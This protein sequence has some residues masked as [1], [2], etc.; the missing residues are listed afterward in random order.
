MEGKRETLFFRKWEEL[1]EFMRI[2]EVRPYWEVLNRKKTQL[3]L[4]RVVDIVLSLLMIVLLSVPMIVVAVL[5]RVDSPGPVFF[6]Q[7][8]VTSYGKHFM[9]HKFRTMVDN[10]QSLGSTV[11]VKGDSRI[12]RVGQTLRKL[13][14]DEL[15]QLFDVLSGDMSFVGTRPEAVKYV[16]MYRP[17]YLATLL[18]PAGITSAAS[19]R[20]KDE[21]ELL[22]GADDVDSVYI[23]QILPEK[24]KWNLKSIEEFSLIGDLKTMFRTVGAVLSKE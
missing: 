9:I 19:I 1:P 24:M 7:A 3:I 4:K 23:K 15:P 17:E 16:E 8:R 2:P 18:M 20:Y 14:I 22:N 13:R 6:R 5:I 12:T 21:D 11:T 10:A